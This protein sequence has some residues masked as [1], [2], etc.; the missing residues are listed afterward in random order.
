L[1]KP[2]LAGCAALHALSNNEILT[3]LSFQMAELSII[4]YGIF[5]I[6][7]TPSTFG[8]GKT[9]VKFFFWFGV[10]DY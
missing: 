4:E 6:F 7:H 8:N 1:E 5:M 10:P 9:M 3:A 2:I